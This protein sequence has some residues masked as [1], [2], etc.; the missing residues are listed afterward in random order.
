MWCLILRYG[1]E[2]STEGAVSLIESKIIRLGALGQNDIQI[3][4]MRHKGKEIAYTSD[5]GINTQGTEALVVQ[6][7]TRLIK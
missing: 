3:S 6:L 2:M 7:L 1:N 5:Q 4:R